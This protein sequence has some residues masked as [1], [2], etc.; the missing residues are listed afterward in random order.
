MPALLL[1]AM[2]S[3]LLAVAQELLSSRE[4]QRTSGLGEAA[5]RAG[6]GAA[7]PELVRGFALPHFF[8]RLPGWAGA[9]CLMLASLASKTLELLPAAATLPPCCCRLPPTSHMP[10]PGRCALPCVPTPT[11]RPHCS[12]MTR[13][14]QGTLENAVEQ[15]ELYRNVLDNRWGRPSQAGG[16]R[17]SASIASACAAHGSSACV[18]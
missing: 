14:L 11:C 7:A 3:R 5:A 4:L 2:T 13:L 9:S 17:A 6:G 10:D 8:S 18:C 12:P 16:L 15:L 1:Q